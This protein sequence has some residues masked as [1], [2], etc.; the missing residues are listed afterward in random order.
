[1]RLVHPRTG[2]VDNVAVHCLSAGEGEEGWARGAAAGEGAG[3]API[4]A[5]GGV[6]SSSMRVG[7]SAGMEGRGAQPQGEARDRGMQAGRAAAVAT[8]RAIG[9]ALGEEFGGE[10][11]KREG[12]RGEAEGR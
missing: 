9:R 1:M 11:K 2:L 5:Q 12:R 6:G 4:G 10:G 8:A 3:E 7:S